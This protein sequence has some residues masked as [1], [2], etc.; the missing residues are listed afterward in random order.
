MTLAIGDGASDV[1]M[2]QAAHCGVAVHGSQGME[3]VAACDFALPRFS[4]LR[5]LL[6]VHGRLNYLRIR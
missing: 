4:D 5:R 2:L 1:S 3:A 6:F